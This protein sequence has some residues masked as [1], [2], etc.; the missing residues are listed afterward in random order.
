MRVGVELQKAGEG[1]AQRSRQN[2]PWA[3]MVVF[4]AVRADRPHHTLG[5]GGA[6]KESFLNNGGKLVLA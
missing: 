3:E 4:T 1:T 6:S 5:V 2:N